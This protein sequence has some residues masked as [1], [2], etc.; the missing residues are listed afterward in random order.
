M[1]LSKELEEK[2][3]T[4]TMSY[5]EKCRPD[6]DIPHTLRAVHWIKE[7]IKKE[8]GNE[9]ILIIAMYLHD[10]GYTP[11]QVGY[12]FEDILES[13]KNHA[14]I[15]AI[16]SKK[17]LKDLSEFSKTEINK[18]CSLIA[19]HHLRNEKIIINWMTDEDSFNQLLVIEAD[20]LAKID[21]Y[22]VTP[23]FNKED[24]IKFLE[25]FKNRTLPCFRTKTG[26]KFVAEIL[27]KAEEYLENMLD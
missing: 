24:I 26:K 10:I 23:N 25:D 2:I 27:Q 21:W 1:N 7:L 5:L 6:W 4:I 20:G 18:I 9:K 17:I 12:N 14:E 3:K 19:H 16:K 13:K 11:L 15:G 8:G 22:H